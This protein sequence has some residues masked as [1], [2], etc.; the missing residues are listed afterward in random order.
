M[1]LLILLV[2]AGALLPIVAAVVTVFLGI[3][4]GHQANGRMALA[5]GKGITLGIVMGLTVSGATV[6]LVLA[7]AWLRDR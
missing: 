6:A 4:K 2:I 1:D 3:P 5:F 7:I